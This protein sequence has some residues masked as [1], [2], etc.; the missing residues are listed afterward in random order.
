MIQHLKSLIFTK[1]GG[2]VMVAVGIFLL[3]LGA[4]IARAD[5]VVI[6]DKVSFIEVYNDK[7]IFR[8]DGAG[9]ITGIGG[10]KIGRLN[11]EELALMHQVFFNRNGWLNDTFDTLNSKLKEAY[12]GYVE[13]M[14][15][16]PK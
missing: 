1:K 14:E 10:R 9:R 5:D 15:L 2:A 7:E 3:V 4:S 6:P 8:I 12:Q 13:P 16:E 11:E